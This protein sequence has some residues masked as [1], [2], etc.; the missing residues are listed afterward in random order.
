MAAVAVR[1]APVTAPIIPP[2]PRLVV[3]MRPMN[4]TEARRLLPAHARP[5]EAVE[6]R[7]DRPTAVVA[8]VPWGSGYTPITIVR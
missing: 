7:L 5:R 3:T 4:I 8:V 6:A 1:R 2:C